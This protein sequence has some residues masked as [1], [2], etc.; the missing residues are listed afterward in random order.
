[1]SHPVLLGH[2]ASGSADSMRPWVAGLK[3][4]GIEAATVPATGK[5]PMKAEKAMEVFRGLAA[6]HPRAVLGGQSYGGRV[7][8]M[9]V[10]EDGGA[11][12][13]LLSYPLHRPGHADEL[14][15]QHWAALKCPVLFLSGEADPFARIDLLR[16]AVAGLPGAEL[17]TYPR[18]GHGLNA[19]RDDALERV[20]R[21]VSGLG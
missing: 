18:V 4:R 13:V 14:R 20:A 1:V 17:H 6:Q 3:Q 5:L 19:V 8:S 11:G 16:E 10:A 12:L 21:F 2:G 15:T 9:V 7:A